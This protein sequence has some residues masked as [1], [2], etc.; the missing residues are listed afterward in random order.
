MTGSLFERISAVLSLGLLAALAL[1]AWLLTE[2]A[3]RPVWDTSY[4]SSSKM[5]A[6][7]MG[8]EITQTDKA[9][10]SR[11][12]IEAPTLSLFDDGSA[13][14][15]APAMLAL[16]PNAP[17]VRARASKAIVSADQ[18][19][20]LLRGQALILRDAYGK[21]SEIRIATD[22]VRFNLD[23]QTADTTAPVR[24]NQG[25]ILLTGVG[26]KFNQKT[27]QIQVLAQSQMVLPGQG[28][29]Q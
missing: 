26:M 6:Q 16:R 4:R 3:L 18:N 21:E 13:E 22:W 23:A 8:A 15:D 14:I 17:P 5:N 12:H 1:A 29:G 25:N 10:Q 7:V 9:G 24:V 28:S 11:F 20:I 19:E 27:E 2:L